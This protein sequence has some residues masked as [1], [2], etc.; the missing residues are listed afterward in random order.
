M[1]GNKATTMQKKL[2]NKGVA[3]R[4]RMQYWKWSRWLGQ[5]GWKPCIVEISRGI[6]GTGEARM[7]IYKDIE[8]DMNVKKAVKDMV[9][10]TR[11]TGGKMKH[12]LKLPAD[13][14]AGLSQEGEI[15]FMVD[16]KANGWKR[17]QSSLTLKPAPTDDGKFIFQRRAELDPTAALANVELNTAKDVGEVLLQGLKHIQS[18]GSCQTAEDPNALCHAQCTY[19][20]D[21]D[22]EDGCFPP[23]F[24][25]K[26]EHK[27]GGVTC[28]PVKGDR[29]H[30]E[31]WQELLELADERVS[32]MGECFA[33]CS[34]QWE[35]AY[36]VFKWVSD[37]STKI[38]S[39]KIR[40][41]VEQRHPN[42]V[43]A[44]EDS[45]DKLA[46]LNVKLAKAFHS[47]ADD[48]FLK[49]LLRYKGCDLGDGGLLVDAAAGGDKTPEEVQAMID[50]AVEG[51]PMLAEVDNGN[52]AGQHMPEEH[53]AN[54]DELRATKKA[55]AKL[56]D[57]EKLSEISKV[58]GVEKMF[59]EAKF[60]LLQ[61]SGA[62]ASNALR[63]AGD[64]CLAVYG[65]IVMAAGLVVILIG[66]LFAFVAKLICWAITRLWKED[67][68]V[69]KA[70]QK[71]R[72]FQCAFIPQAIGTVIMMI[73]ATVCIVGLIMVISDNNNGPG[74]F[75][76]GSP[77][78]YYWGSAWLWYPHYYPPLPDPSDLVP[79]LGR[80]DEVPWNSSSSKVEH[81]KRQEE[82][83]RN[84][85]YKYEQRQQQYGYDQA[86]PVYG[87]ALNNQGPQNGKLVNP[88]AD[89]A[90]IGGQTQDVYGNQ[91]SEYP[92]QQNSVYDNY[93]YD[94]S[95]GKFNY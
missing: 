95:Y 21:L 7:K 64:G 52:A 12:I 68:N 11:K 53:G 35:S 6:E 66:F 86:R 2:A 58:G 74:F 75:V 94:H 61:R 25:Y 71:H 28:K 47:N 37:F 59:A 79:D 62:N 76:I 82:K 48:W 91:Y 50:K 93:A 30:V 57:T 14:E 4:V 16:T 55:L 17:Q 8:D 49:S 3:M 15:E 20:E 23:H 34:S 26:D 44:V 51:C 29:R 83:D 42:L 60:S 18:L 81:S 78:Q 63:C 56:S 54:P 80:P 24:C 22:E 19:I 84:D 45:E 87:Q 13:I 77:P 39:D 1:T 5:A 92:T 70:I 85:K 10:I 31:A 88:Y 41:V 67:T 73:G 72:M 36:R 32:K 38:L 43:Q 69:D 46:K 33:S 9:P 27:A 90:H 65:M 89:E 40:P